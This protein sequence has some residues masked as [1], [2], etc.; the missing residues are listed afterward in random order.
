MMSQPPASFNSVEFNT[1]IRDY[2]AYKHILEPYFG[3]TLLLKRES[4][5]VKD[6]SAVAVME[7]TEDSSWACSL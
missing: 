1:F 4:S 3:E 7:E 2:R 5:N 6:R